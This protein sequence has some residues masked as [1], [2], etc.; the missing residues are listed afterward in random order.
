MKRK[1]SVFCLL[2]MLC[3]NFCTIFSQAYV[4]STTGD[5]SSTTTAYDY[6]ICPGSN[7]AKLGGDTDSATVITETTF[8]ERPVFEVSE[9]DNGGGKNIGYVYISNINIDVAEYNY[10]IVDCYYTQTINTPLLRLMETTGTTPKWFGYKNNGGIVPE[11]D[12]WQTLVFPIASVCTYGT[13]AQLD[14]DDTI[15]AVLL[16][17]YGDGKKSS[18]FTDKTYIS[19]ITFSQNIPSNVEKTYPIS[20]SAHQISTSATNEGA[21]D[22]RF[23]ATLNSIEQGFE[24]VG[25]KIRAKISGSMGYWELYD[26]TVYE[27]IS[28]QTD[29]GWIEYTAKQLGG[30]YIAASSINGI[31]ANEIIHFLVT[32]CVRLSD[33]TVIDGIS[34]VVTYKAGENLCDTIIL[35]DGIGS[36][37]EDYL[38]VLDALALQK[39]TEILC[40]TPKLDGKTCYYISNNGSD[41]NDGRSPDKAWKS[42]NKASLV[43]ESNSAVLFERGGIWRGTLWTKENVTYSNYGDVS[44]SLPII[45]GSKQ[46]Y[47]DSSLW[48]STSYP[49]VW[50]CTLSFNNVGIMAFEHNGTLGNYGATVG[51]LLFNNE[52]SYTVA[53]LCEDL[54]F[55]CDTDLDNTR[56]DTLYLYS[57]E[58]PG[59]RFAS[60]EIGENIS[61][62]SMSDGITIDG[63]RV[64]YSGGIAI[65]SGDLEN[66]TVKNCVAEWIGGSKFSEDSTY[67][68]AIQVY[69]NA[70]NCTFVDNWCYQIYDCGITVQKSDNSTEEDFSIENISISE[71]LIEYCFWGIEYW[72]NINNNTTSNSVMRDIY[73]ENNFIRHTGYGW[74]G[75]VRDEHY[76]STALVNQTAAICCFGL[77]NNVSNIVIR[78]NLLQFSKQSLLCV[79]YEEAVNHT[80]Q[81]NI[82]VQ[83]Y[84][85]LLVKEKSTYIYCYDDRVQEQLTNVLNDTSTTVIVSD[86]T[87]KIQS[88]TL[89][90]DNS[91]NEMVLDF[92]VFGIN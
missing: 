50:K 74:G 11:E 47:A 62:I 71:N 30:N 13:Q 75:S 6:I 88:P 60:I 4:N 19:S 23:L 24:Q 29:K 58:N 78:N 79:A 70:S 28:A 21:R 36:S 40:S 32:P 67:G 5:P 52:T 83:E 49:N 9:K 41:S 15:N 61:C 14:P 82:L 1:I 45:S 69:G 38:K 7:R 91:A 22:I 2:V 33:E 68:N 10:V 57:T 27:K 16:Q 73:I 59:T 55:Y 89:V 18:N 12:I 54:Q 72:L 26:D 3:V 65:G 66:A 76:N 92:D 86:R 90:L 43:T 39:R 35:H 63:L 20:Y 80:Y 85:G 48:V 25:F 87:T 44:K 34:A 46:N 53:D 84:N 51:K 31:P 37:E 77:P 8:D 56:D 42:L 17:L 81:D 64:Q